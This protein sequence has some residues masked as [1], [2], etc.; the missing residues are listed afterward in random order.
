MHR[1]SFIEDYKEKS[2]ILAP[3]IDA[4]N[5]RDIN[6]LKKLVEKLAEDGVRLRGHLLEY[7]VICMDVEIVKFLISQK[8]EIEDPRQLCSYAASSGPEIMACIYSAVH[9]S[10]DD[11]VLAPWRKSPDDR[12]RRLAVYVDQHLKSWLA[13]TPQH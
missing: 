8:C 6:T 1:Y 2:A 3:C 13:E 11:Y 4:I 5:K 10:Y 7:A 12:T 9:Y